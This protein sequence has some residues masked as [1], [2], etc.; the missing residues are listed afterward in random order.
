M[1]SHGCEGAA[2]QRSAREG[3]APRQLRLQ[4]LPLALVPAADS[5]SGRQCGVG[6]M[7]PRKW[8]YIQ[9]EILFPGKISLKSPINLGKITR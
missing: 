4:P 2:A 3:A 9:G 5:E 7:F 8:C 6:L 1:A